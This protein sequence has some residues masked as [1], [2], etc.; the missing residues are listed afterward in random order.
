MNWENVT[1]FFAEDERTYNGKYLEICEVYDDKLEVSLFSSKDSQFEIYLS[2]GIFY[3][4]IYVEKETEYSLRQ[5]IKK[6]LVE[7]YSG[8]KE[9]TG[10]FINAFAE[11]YSVCLPD[12]IFFNFDIS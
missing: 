4:I 6:A 12:D 10:D 1:E 9:P 8:K 3:G 5:E 11:K 7:E 2:F